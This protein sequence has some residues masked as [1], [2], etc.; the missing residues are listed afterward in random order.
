M[1]TKTPGGDNRCHYISPIVE[2]GDFGTIIE[3]EDGACRQKLISSYEL[4]S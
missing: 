4:R 1:A 2:K 3:A